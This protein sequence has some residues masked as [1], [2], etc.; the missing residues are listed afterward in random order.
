MGWAI[1]PIGAAMS[2]G[3]TPSEECRVNIMPCNK[4]DGDSCEEITYDNRE[5]NWVAMD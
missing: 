5:G 1:G 3:C 4:D 2:P